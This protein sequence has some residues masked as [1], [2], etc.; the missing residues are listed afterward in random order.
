MRELCL[1]G[2]GILFAFRSKLLLLREASSLIKKLLKVKNEM[3]V[4]GLSTAQSNADA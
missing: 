1:V 2:V 4:A 3:S